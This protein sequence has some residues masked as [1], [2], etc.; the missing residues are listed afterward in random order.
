MNIHAQLKVIG[1]LLVERGVLTQ[2]QLESVR[3]QVGQGEGAVSETADL[4]RVLFEKGVL[5]E[6]ELLR[7]YSGH[8]GMPFRDLKDLE[9]DV[10]VAHLI[11]PQFAGKNQVI[12]IAK[13]GDAL[14]VALRDPFNVAVIDELKILTGLDIKPVLT[15]SRDIGEAIRRS[16]GMGAET[17]ERLVRDAAAAVRKA[18]PDEGGAPE[19]LE[20]MAA[21]IVSFVDQLIAEACQQRATDIHI[22]TYR[23]RLR[24]RYRVDGVLRETKTSPD[25][26]KLRPAILSRFK[27]MAS[28]DIAEKRRPQDGRCQVVVGAQEV[29]LRLSFFPTLFGEG[30]SIRLLPRSSGRISLSDLGMSPDDLA[31]MGSVLARSNGVVLATGPTGCGKS[32]TLYACLNRIND[33]AVNIVTLEDPVEYQMDGIN[34]IQ[35]NPHVDLT[36]SHGLRSVLRQDPDVIMVG[37]IRDVETAQIA[38]RAALTGHLILS[39]LHTNDAVASLTRLFDM[40]V[41]PYFVADTLRA[42]VAQR[43][44]RRVCPSCRESYAPGAREKA[45]WGAD[46]IPEGAQWARGRGC[47]ACQDSGFK[48]RIGIYEVFV[49]TDAIREALVDRNVSPAALREAA[50]REG[51]VTLLEDGLA[52]VNAGIT[53][54]QEVV[55]VVQQEA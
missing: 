36:F 38:V 21:S 9:I 2:E 34:Q 6:E 40:G 55:R 32:T 52:K 53:T 35:I 14:V 19:D 44:V 37:E 4:E 39:T 10:G 18:A 7:A 22:E 26:K 29:D 17:V 51:M 42:V 12:A 28:L 24:V 15:R 43:L 13:E 1:A 16:Y 20:E 5:T 31:K 11:P 48:G 23:D 46:R 54:S 41:E 8:F 30:V 47:A 25:V 33:P 3:R 49:I 50:R 45:F 27:I